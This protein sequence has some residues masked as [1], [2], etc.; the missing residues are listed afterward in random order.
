MGGCD[1][2]VLSAMAAMRTNSPR[3]CE[4]AQPIR[5]SS[6]NT[7]MTSAAPITTAALDRHASLAMT[8]EARHCEEAQPTRQS[9]A[10]HP[11]PHINP[12]HQPLS[13]AQE[14][15]PAIKIKA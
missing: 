4:D 3:H 14:S 15:P 5:Q 2:T 10:A 1:N 6:G 12:S 11:Q 13:L 9:S 8:I 7:S